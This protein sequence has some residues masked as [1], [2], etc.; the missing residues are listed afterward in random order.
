MTL[1][2][3]IYEEGY[4]AYFN[5]GYDCPY[6]RVDDFEKAEIWEAGWNQACLDDSPY[7]EEY[8]LEGNWA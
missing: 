4:A 6:C 8:E 5:D 2:S 7:D 1:M 3:K